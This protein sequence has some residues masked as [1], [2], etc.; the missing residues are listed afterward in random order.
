[1]V[2]QSPSVQQA[3][4]ECG[5]ILTVK[6]TFIVCEEKQDD[7]EEGLLL[8]T[9]SAPALVVSDVGGALNACPSPAPALVVSNKVEVFEP[10][11]L[12]LSRLDSIS[13][14]ATASSPQDLTRRNDIAL[15]HAAGTCKPCNYF[16][17]REDGCRKGDTCEFCHL[18]TS[19]D[20]QKRKK[21]KTPKFKFSKQGDATSAR[22][23][24]PHL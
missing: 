24:K 21:K 22:R 7:E 16:A 15:A 11:R 13:T 17:F 10:P 6:N 4:E 3:A 19:D 1:M 9:S 23:G 14:T 5:F 20:I 2:P 8:R 18:C 12:P